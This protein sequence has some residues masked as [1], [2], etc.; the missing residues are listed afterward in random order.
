VGGH[1]YWS[2][3]W[4]GGRRRLGESV[5]KGEFERGHIYRVERMNRGMRKIK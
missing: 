4:G 2:N 5:S 3:G 1:Y